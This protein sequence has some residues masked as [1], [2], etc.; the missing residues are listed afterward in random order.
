MPPQ[1]THIVIGELKLIDDQCIRWKDVTGEHADHMEDA[2]AYRPVPGRVLMEGKP[3]NAKMH[4]AREGKHMRLS[5]IGFEVDGIP[6][7]RVR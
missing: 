3:Y 1:E 6:F 4:F 2:W 7:T 5:L